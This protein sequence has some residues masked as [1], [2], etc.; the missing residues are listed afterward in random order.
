MQHITLQHLPMDPPPGGAMGL[1]KSF[2]L[3]EKII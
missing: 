3:P 2:S 1:R